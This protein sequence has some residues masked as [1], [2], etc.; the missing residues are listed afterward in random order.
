MKGAVD[1]PELGATETLGDT[2]G[3]LEGP[4]DNSDEG[5]EEGVVLKLIYI[6]IYWQLIDSHPFDAISINRK[7]WNKVSIFTSS[8]GIIRYRMAG[9]EAGLW[10]N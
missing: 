6:Y 1:G 3:E 8:A 4:V 5:P 2:D 9:R 10:T 7:P